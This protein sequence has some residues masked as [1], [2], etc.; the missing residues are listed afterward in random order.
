M[1]A[2]TLLVGVYSHNSPKPQTNTAKKTHFERN[3]NHIQLGPLPP[4][5]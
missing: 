3:E 4:L 1:T 2:C 5:L